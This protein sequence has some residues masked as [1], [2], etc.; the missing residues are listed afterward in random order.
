MAVSFQIVLGPVETTPEVDSTNAELLRRARDGEP[1]GLVLVADHQTAGR[2]RLGRTW[3][4]QPG[5]ALLVSVLL[6]PALPPDEL[7]RV[8]FAAAL[9][10]RDACTSV[11]SVTPDIKWPNDL[12]IGDHKLAGLL[13]ES[14]V[15]GARVDAV[16]VGM[17]LNLRATGLPAGAA[18]VDGVDRDTLLR[19]WLDQLD[20]RLADTDLLGQ[21]RAA[22]AT[23]G[24]H[25][26]VERPD[27][28]LEGVA[29]GVDDLGR[30]V[31]D[32]QA[33]AAGD[34]IHVRAIEDRPDR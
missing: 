15:T 22:C 9:A 13:A 20:A 31:V 11:A 19:A 33:V 4:A 24:R 3:E 27:G 30:L 23:I 32:G 14:V 10:A 16:V 2:G 7:F 5:A 12:L 17:G 1:H 26:R 6:R 28:P 8:T 25:I 21:Y 34:V 29:S 18:A